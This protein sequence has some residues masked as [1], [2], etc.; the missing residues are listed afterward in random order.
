[1]EVRRI[2]IGCINYDFL[3][4]LFSIDRIDFKICTELPFE[5]I[6]I[7]SQIINILLL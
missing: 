3:A 2:Y 6:Y 5:V 4:Y 1:M 7:V